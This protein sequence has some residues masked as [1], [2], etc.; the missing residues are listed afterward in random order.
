MMD[1][2]PNKRKVTDRRKIERRAPKYGV[3]A[4]IEDR[5]PPQYIHNRFV[6]KGSG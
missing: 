5:K 6:K 4:R 1:D 3:N 2:K